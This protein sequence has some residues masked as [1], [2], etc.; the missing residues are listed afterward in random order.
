MLRLR[1]SHCV[2]G[3]AAFVL[4]NPEDAAAT[5]KMYWADDTTAKIQRANLDGSS[6]ENLVTTGLS[7]PFGIAIIPE[8]STA[9]LLACGLAVMAVG[10]G[11]R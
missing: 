9:L 6:V 11:R 3:L 7:G 4:V 1:F 5:P 8:P 10:R 2:A